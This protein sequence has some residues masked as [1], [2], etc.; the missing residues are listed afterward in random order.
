MARRRWVRGRVTAAL[1]TCL[2][3]T[4]PAAASAAA[5]TRKPTLLLIHGGA[6]GFDDPTS[7]DDA[8]RVAAARGFRPVKLEYT[9]WNLPRA[10]DDAMREAKRYASQGPVFAYGESVGGTLAELVARPGRAR[11]AVAYAPVS[12]L[13]NWLGDRPTLLHRLKATRADLRRGSPALRRAT[14]PILAMVPEH[15]SVD[16]SQDTNRWAKK[17][18][19]VRARTVA[20][21]HTFMGTAEY[22]GNLRLAMR[23]LHDRA[24]GETRG[25]RSDRRTSGQ[26]LRATAAAAM[27]S[28]QSS[29]GIAV[30]SR[31][32]WQM[33]GSCRSTP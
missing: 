32:R 15:D 24:Y 22:A 2:V 3:L 30:E 27:S 9:L 12:N 23:W 6:F 10:L 31:T 33:P 19:L 26:E 29:S 4:A 28:T 13:V 5:D 8:A 14:K 16:S 25:Q 11:A 17:D 1:A 20:G 21:G 18:P 7:M